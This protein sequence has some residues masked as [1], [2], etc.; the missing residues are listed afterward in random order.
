MGKDDETTLADPQRGKAISSGPQGKDSVSSDPQGKD[1]AS[2]NPGDVHSTSSD[3]EQVDPAS[4]DPARYISASFDVDYADRPSGKAEDVDYAD[5][6][7]GETDAPQ[8]YV[9]L[10]HQVG[11]ADPYSRLSRLL[12]SAG[13]APWLPPVKVDLADLAWKPTRF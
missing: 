3:P 4:S 8:A 1:C 5:R 9:T 7:S 11:L 6:P 10:N 13:Q 12:R 2:S